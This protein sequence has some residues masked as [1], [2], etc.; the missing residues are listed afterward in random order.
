MEL[1]QGIL[2]FDIGEQYSQAAYLYRG[3]KEAVCVNMDEG[4]DSYLLPNIACWNEHKLYYSL[5]AEKI[6]AEGEGDKIEDMLQ[7]VRNH[8]SI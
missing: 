1:K 6:L 8:E 5:E 7:H 2:G 4:E 3:E